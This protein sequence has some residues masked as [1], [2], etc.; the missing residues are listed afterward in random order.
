MRPMHCSVRVVWW[1]THLIIIVWKIFRGSSGKMGLLFY[2][3]FVNIFVLAQKH[4]REIARDGHISLK[5]E[6]HSRQRGSNPRSTA[7]E[8]V[9]LPLGHTGYYNAV[10]YVGDPC[11]K[12]VI[13][14]N[15]LA[16]FTF[17]PLS[18]ISSEVAYTTHKYITHMCTTHKVQSMNDFGQMYIN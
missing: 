10:G 1:L 17:V 5:G 2:I 11:F 18:H 9:A 4:G 12:S 3:A 16:V 14:T 7:Y 6:K 15:K 8:A 13:I